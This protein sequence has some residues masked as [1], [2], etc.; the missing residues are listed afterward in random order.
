MSKEGKGPW[1]KN[2]AETEALLDRHVSGFK[3]DRKVMF[4]APCYFVN[5]NMFAGA[6]S[7]RIFARFSEKDREHMT[8]EGL[9]EDFVPKSGRTM[10][11]Y[12]VFT[13]KAV[14]DPS[15]L[16]LWLGRSFAYVSSLP[17]KAGKPRHKVP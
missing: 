2:S 13:A 15:I 4:G 6:F 3:A 17:R 5:G 9:G 11:E 16:D 8:E 10:K 1:P 7:D 14:G 12:R